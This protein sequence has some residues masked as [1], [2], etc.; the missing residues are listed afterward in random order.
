MLNSKLN[1]VQNWQN[2]G[3]KLLKNWRPISLLNVDFKILAKLFGLRMKEILPTIISNDQVGY[4]KERYIGQNIRTIKDV[5]EICDGNEIGI[6]AFLDFEKAFDSIEWNFLAESLKAFNFGENFLK[7]VSIL[8]TDIQ[9]CVT[10]NGF[11]TAF[12]NLT[13]GVRQGCPLSP[14]L[15]IIAAETLSHKIRNSK[16]IQGID[17]HNSTVKIVQM[18]DDTTV[19]A[20]DYNVL[21]IMDKLYEAAG[22]KLN[23]G[24]TE[25]MWLGIKGHRKKGLGIKWQ[26]DKIFP[27]GIWFCKN[28][29]F[30]EYLN[31]GKAYDKC[32]KILEMWSHR[33]L[34]LK[35]RIAVIK[36]YAL[37]KLLYVFNNVYVPEPIIKKVKNTFFSYLWEDKPEKVKRSTIIQD[38]ELGGLKMINFEYMFKSMK[39]MWVK[40]MMMNKE[41]KWLLF[42]KSAIDIELEDFIKCNFCKKSIPGNFS[43]FYKQVFSYWAEITESTLNLDDPWCLRRQPIYYNRHILSGGQ[44]Y[45]KQWKSTIYNS[46][47]KIIQDICNTNGT[48]MSKQQLEG[49]YNMHISIME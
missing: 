7:W 12:F 14:Y 4:L 11:S 49:S 35:G 31:V 21:S 24:K 6:L 29:E 20:K 37:P 28:E 15:F 44:Y 1:G 32:C 46:N 26:D 10:N 34:S 23:K 30:D 16:N 5:I 19:F 43:K 8:Y 2:P 39:A 18:A 36:S 13:R 47:I 22:L 40:R 38:Y 25:A 17:I 27:L 3:H 41:A 33:K 48:I 9:A 42:A 45:N